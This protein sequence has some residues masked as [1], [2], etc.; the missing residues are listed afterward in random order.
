MARK[1]CLSQIDSWF[2]ESCY[3][4]LRDRDAENAH[5][6]LS[7]QLAGRV[8]VRSQD[9]PP[10]SGSHQRK[11]VIA[12]ISLYLNYRGMPLSSAYSLNI[13]SP[14]MC[15]GMPLLPIS[16]WPCVSNYVSLLRHRFSI[17]SILIFLG[18]RKKCAEM[19]EVTV[20]VTD[21]TIFIRN[22]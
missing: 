2:P 6:E 17:R 12:N 15:P 21:S 11:S 18:I 14:A 3:A 1:R 10:R 19:S 16:F 8:E 22:W 9:A 13:A 4:T 5:H 7:V 20:R